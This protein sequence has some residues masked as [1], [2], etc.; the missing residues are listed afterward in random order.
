MAQ[1]VHERV[2]ALLGGD[3]RR[4]DLARTLA[5]EQRDGS[6]H[7]SIEFRSAEGH[8]L[9]TGRE[10]TQVSRAAVEYW[11][12]GLETVFLEGAL[13]RAERLT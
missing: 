2:V 10:T 6:W 12:E 5:E 1:I 3:G 13:A 4:Y 7:G 11:A 8:V 9:R